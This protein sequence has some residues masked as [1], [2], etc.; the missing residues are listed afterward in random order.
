MAWAR[1]PMASTGL[2]PLK[3]R[4]AEMQKNLRWNGRYRAP[5]HRFE[6]P[7]R[8]QTK[9]DSLHQEQHRVAGKSQD[10]IDH[11]QRPE[12]PFPPRLGIHLSLLGSTMRLSK[13]ACEAGDIG[14]KGNRDAAKDP[15]RCDIHI[16]LSG[17]SSFNSLM[18]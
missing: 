5:R 17:G 11:N 7:D 9:T 1:K 3:K 15:S 4:C 13:I 2:P 12:M 14:P 16:R 8:R 18:A 10:R 6:E